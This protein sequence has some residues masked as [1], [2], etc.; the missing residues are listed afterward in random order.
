[1]SKELELLSRSVNFDAEVICFD[2]AD[3][4]P[5]FSD[6]ALTLPRR[7]DACY[8]RKDRS[9]FQSIFGCMHE[10]HRSGR[11]K[12]GAGCEA[13]RFGRLTKAENER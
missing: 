8:F 11:Q 10:Q 9:Q 13:A 3:G 5:R 7:C 2:A 4:N 12:S 1:M 6:S